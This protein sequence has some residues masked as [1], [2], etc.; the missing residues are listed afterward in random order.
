MKDE[1]QAIILSL[2]RQIAFIDSQLTRLK[3]N[4]EGSD[5]ISVKDLADYHRFGE[6]LMF[7]VKSRQMMSNY[8]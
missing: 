1:V 5:S 2:D 7:L 3:N 6:S 4:I 8:E